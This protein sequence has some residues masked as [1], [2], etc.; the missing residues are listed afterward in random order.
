VRWQPSFFVK[1]RKVARGEPT[2]FIAD[3]ASSHDGDL[4][5]AHDL[6][7]RAAEAGADCAKFQ[8]FLAK[9]I[10]SDQG[11]RALGGQQAHQ[12]GWSKSVYDVFEACETPRDWT[13][14]LVETCAKA[15][16]D[17]MTTPYDSAAIAMMRPFV[18]AW[19]IGSGDMTWP[20]FISE[21]AAEGLPLFLATGASDLEETKVAVEAALRVNPSLCLMQC[22]TNYTGSLENF[23]AVNLNVLRAFADLWPDMP[24]GLSDHTPGHAAVLGAVALGACAVEKHFTD[25]NTREGP[26]HAFSM[27]PV[28]WRDMVDRTRELE[29]ALGDGIKR[30]EENEFSSRVVQRRALRLTR[31][32]P[33]GHVVAQSDVEAL[34]PC[35]VDALTPADI[36]K[37]LG[38]AL[39]G[40][41]AKGAYLSEA[42]LAL[43]KLDEPA[44][45]AA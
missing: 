22:N 35:P 38:H 11:F 19:K 44:I 24:L 43:A 13:A 33:A 36:D 28:T 9:D 3:I 10:V 12:A 32:L 8:H 14:A 29:M 5:R 17:Y 27:N 45:T 2:Y 30:V 41:M 42:A 34:R 26:D 39:A 6:I 7:W 40:P 4:Q 23:R 1:Q 16:I 18:S 31:D 21:V 15:G 25:D 20:A 37:V